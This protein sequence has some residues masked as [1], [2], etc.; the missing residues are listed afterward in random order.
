MNKV[1]EVMKYGSLETMLEAQTTRPYSKEVINHIK[2]I[3]RLNYKPVPKILSSDVFDTLLIRSEKSEVRRFYEISTLVAE[4]LSNQNGKQFSTSDIFVLR[5]LSNKLSYSL[6]TKVKGIRE[7]S[8]EE[9]NRSIL[10]YLGFNSTYAEKLTQIEIEYEKTEIEL[11]KPFW[12]FL[13]EMVADGSKVVLVSDMYIHRKEIINIIKDKVDD[14]EEVV[15]DLISS[16][17]TKINKASGHIFQY[18]KKKYSVKGEEV[19]HFGD[20]FL[21]DY[22]KPN[23]CGIRGVYLPQPTYYV[24]KLKLDE[25]QVLS[26]LAENDILV[27]SI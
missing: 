9:I 12:N 23:L 4:Y 3:I 26:K 22:Q 8:I 17:D 20:A 13:K 19:I 6:T 7:G 5:N 18:L 2:E 15:H 25:K 11:N 21:G 10:N 24:E 14:F 27:N 16:A 1:S